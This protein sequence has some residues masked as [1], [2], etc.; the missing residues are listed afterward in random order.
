[1]LLRKS[2]LMLWSCCL[3][4]D[5]LS[6]GKTN[7]LKNKHVCLKPGPDTPIINPLLNL[8]SHIHSHFVNR[9]Y[10]SKLEIDNKHRHRHLLLHD[11][12]CNGC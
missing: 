11:I 8:L 1:M 9:N 3:P 2:C 4:I 12:R 6:V 7:I 5:D 10:L